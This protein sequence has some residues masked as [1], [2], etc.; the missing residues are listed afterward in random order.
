MSVE[1][2]TRRGG[3]H[4]AALPVIFI[5]YRRVDTE[6]FTALLNLKLE[7]HIGGRAS[8]FWDHGDIEYGDD[9]PAK[10]EESLK[11][12]KALVA[13]IGDQWLGVLD[14]KTGRRRLENEKDFVRKEIAFALAA[15]LPVLPVLVQDAAPLAAEDLPED[16]KPLAYRNAVVIRSVRHFDRDVKDLTRALEKLVP[17]ARPGWRNKHPLFKMLRGYGVQEY[18][19]KKQE[20]SRMLKFVGIPLLFFFA[21]LVL[22][23]LTL[24][25][26]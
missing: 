17:R 6:E 12:S 25:S 2:T 7:S 4:S 13:V 26:C 14:E 21:L 5:C 10:I 16:L 11:A 8:V 1:P 3:A 15:G 9:F 19:E 18:N 22:L 20:E 23:N 24:G